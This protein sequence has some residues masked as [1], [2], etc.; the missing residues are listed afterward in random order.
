[1]R[2]GSPFSIKGE[3]VIGVIH[4]PCHDELYSG[5]SG[6]GAT[7]NGR[8]LELESTKTI[9]NAVTGI[10]ANHHVYAGIG[11][12]D[13]RGSASRRRQFRAARLGRVMIAYVAAGRLVGY[14]EPY[15]HALGLSRRLLPR[16]RSRR[17]VPAISKR[18]RKADERRAGSGS[19]SRRD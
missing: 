2:L 6:M 9:R 3:P 19:R 18:R 5:A 11:R 4:V 10:G 1:M 16:A 8:Q 13:R 17:L 12:E 14:Y 7:L 15:M